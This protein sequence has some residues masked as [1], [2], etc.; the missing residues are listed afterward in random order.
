L[1]E[2]ATVTLWAV[3]YCGPGKTFRRFCFE[4]G[5]FRQYLTMPR[6]EPSDLSWVKENPWKGDKFSRGLTEEIMNGDIN[7]MFHIP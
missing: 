1:K 3:Y 6:N 4:G 5:F 7:G 2:P